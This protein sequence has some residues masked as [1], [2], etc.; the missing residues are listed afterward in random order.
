[1][2]EWYRPLV[3]DHDT[4]ACQALLG[5]LTK[6]GGCLE[7]DTRWLARRL[8]GVR[9]DSRLQDT[10]AEDSRRENT[11]ALAKYVHS[12]TPDIPLIKAFHLTHVDALPGLKYVEESKKN[13]KTKMGNLREML[14]A[15][16]DMSIFRAVENGFLKLLV[17]SD[18]C[19][20]QFFYLGEVHYP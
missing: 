19:V 7:R 1:M 20:S 15:V 6:F 2:N 5:D 13:K 8:F 4:A 11:I 10:V 3:S 18:I 16:G 14:S 17:D 12:R 9:E